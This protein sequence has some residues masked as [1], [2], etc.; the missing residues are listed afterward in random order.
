LTIN[1]GSKFWSNLP[2]SKKKSSNEGIIS[3]EKP[4]EIENNSEINIITN[5][6]ISKEELM[7]VLE[8]GYGASGNSMLIDPKLNSC[9]IFSIN[10]CLFSSNFNLL[11]SIFLCPPKFVFLLHLGYIIEPYII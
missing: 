9:S 6:E 4:F 5:E 10:G 2:I 1:S 11:L 7:F 3:K 8:N